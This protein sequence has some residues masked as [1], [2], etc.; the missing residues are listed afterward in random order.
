[1][2]DNYFLKIGGT[3]VFSEQLFADLSSGDAETRQKAETFLNERLKETRVRVGTLLKIDNIS[4][5]IGAGASMKA[6]G[7]GL[8]SIPVELENDLHKK[9]VESG[10]DDREWL[11]LFY[12]TSSAL[13]GQTF[14]LGDR[15]TALT[16]DLGQVPKIPLNLEDYLGHLYMWRA[17]MSEFATGIAVSL[18]AGG[19]LA[20]SRAGID[21]LI[22]EIKRGL[23]SL[24]DLPTRGKEAALKDHRRLI[25][26]ILTRPP[27]LRRANLFTLNYDTLIERAADAEGAVLVDGFVG[28]LRRIFRPES[29]DLDFYFPAQTTEGR[30]HRF[31]RALHLYKLHGSITWHRCVADWE[32]PYG[33]FATFCNQETPED[34]VLIYPSPLKYGQALGLPYSELFRRLGSVIAQPQSVLFTVG[35][36]FGD[37]HV[38]ALIRQALA[39]PSFTLVVIDPAPT[40]DFVGR[41]KE[42]G[43]ERVWLV[44]GWQL[45]TLEDFVE[46]L[47]PDLREEEITFKVMKTYNALTPSRQNSEPAPE[48]AD[49]S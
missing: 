36:G 44:S 24:V 20:L 42:L 27:N 39:I 19:T 46:K 18:A 3:E 31:D 17:G 6:G 29:Y 32:N 13:A 2:N 25:R 9:A 45:G 41:L 22:L 8:A 43:D 16:G 37:E 35:Y 4:F 40:S 11:S 14:N 23:T 21:R 7:I 15:R 12:A 26:K 49:D 1:M 5:L 10:N 38:N 34:D 28:T 48:D 47:L 33:V 30:V